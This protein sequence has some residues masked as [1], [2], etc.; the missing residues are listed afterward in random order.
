MI[1]ANSFYLTKPCD[2]N[3][4]IIPDSDHG[5]GC[6]MSGGIEGLAGSRGRV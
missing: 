3:K 1:N 2:L 6:H 5:I 4:P